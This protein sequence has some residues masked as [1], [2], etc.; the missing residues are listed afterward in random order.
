MNNEYLRDRNFLP[1]GILIDHENEQESE[2]ENYHPL[3][4]TTE[5]HSKRALFELHCKRKPKG[6]KRWKR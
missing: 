5:K 4:H 2:L 6:I 3:A 1:V